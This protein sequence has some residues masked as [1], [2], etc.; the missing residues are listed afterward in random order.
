[1]QRGDRKTNRRYEYLISLLPEKAT[2]GLLE[3]V[4]QD[5]FQEK[6]KYYIN[7]FR[8]INP[9]LT[10]M[11]DGGIGQN[12]FKY[13]LL[14]EQKIIGEKIRSANANRP[15][16]LAFS[17]NLSENR[18]GAKNTMAGRS[19]IGWIVCFKDNIPIRMFKYGFEINQFTGSKSGYGNVAKLFT[20]GATH[21]P[22][23]HDWKKFSEC[24]KEVQDIVE[25]NY[26]SIS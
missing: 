2:I 7:M 24:S 14:D 16:P 10:N 4:N 17:L 18:T 1:M 5:N 8:T 12:T 11:T 9:N 19:K 15:K 25:S 22:Y 3:E 23:K 26:E 20:K 6:E 13:Q 21:K